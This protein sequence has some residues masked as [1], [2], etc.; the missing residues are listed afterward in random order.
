MRGSELKLAGEEL[1]FDGRGWTLPSSRPASPWVSLHRSCTVIG[2]CIGSLAVL[3]TILRLQPIQKLAATATALDSMAALLEPPS[4]P[5]SHSETLLRQAPPLHSALLPSPHPPSLLLMSSAH[6]PSPPLPL[7]PHPTASL[8]PPS[9]SILTLPP[10][11]IHPR[12]PPP[13]S[14]SAP[15]VPLPSVPLPLSTVVLLEHCKAS[16]VEYH[17]WLTLWFTGTV[18]RSSFSTVLDGLSLS[19]SVVLVDPQGLAHDYA[20]LTQLLQLAYASEP[21]GSTHVAELE[22]IVVHRS[23]TSMVELSFLEIQS[24]AGEQLNSGHLSWR[25]CVVTTR[26]A[27]AGTMTGG[28]MWSDI[29]ERLLQPC[30]ITMTSPESHGRA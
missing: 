21:A 27:C 19:P 16:L 28:V 29:V 3:L 15:S 13:P 4:K 12:A 5:P 14:L 26:A 17:H 23:N 24:R 2:A 6:P 7:P 1:E 10:P 11:L 20:A 30:E 18:P 8:P 25:R 9:F 22:S